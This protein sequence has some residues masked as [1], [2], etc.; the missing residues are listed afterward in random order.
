MALIFSN[1]STGTTYLTNTYEVLLPSNHFQYTQFWQSRP[2]HPFKS[3]ET[4]T[5][6]SN[7]TSILRIEPDT[8]RNTN[9]A[10]LSN[11]WC[12]LDYTLKG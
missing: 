12:T 5:Q 1:I 11:V 4:G 7:P 6:R 9:S 3:K 2:E 10:A 8:Y